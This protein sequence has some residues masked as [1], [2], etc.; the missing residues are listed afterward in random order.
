MG[1]VIHDFERK[2]ASGRCCKPGQRRPTKETKTI[3]LETESEIIDRLGNW[4]EAN[5]K[6]REIAI[7]SGDGESEIIIWVAKVLSGADVFESLLDVVELTSRLISEGRYVSMYW[8]F[9]FFEEEA[10]NLMEAGLKYFTKDNYRTELESE[11]NKM[12]PYFWAQYLNPVSIP[13]EVDYVWLLDGD[14]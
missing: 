1:H 12:K 13:S 7:R 14:I 10:K 2:Y 3:S 5:K 11:P 6:S 8:K 4:F 9:F